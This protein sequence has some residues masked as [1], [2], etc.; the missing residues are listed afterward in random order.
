MTRRESLCDRARG[1]LAFADVHEER[2]NGCA[3]DEAAR[4]LD[5]LLAELEQLDGVRQGDVAVQRL[6][7][8][9]ATPVREAIVAQL[10][11]RLTRSCPPRR[12]KGRTR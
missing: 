2:D 1:L 3:V 11:A 12:V 7:D 4:D 10:R 9:G 5:R 6:D 8:F